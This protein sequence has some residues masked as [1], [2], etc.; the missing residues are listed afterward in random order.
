MHAPRSPAFLPLTPLVSPSSRRAG[1]ADLPA[2]L[3]LAQRCA[4]EEPSADLLL[5]HH[6]FDR[7]FEPAEPNSR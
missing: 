4:A 5:L 2:L 1:E 3:S 6:H 7:H